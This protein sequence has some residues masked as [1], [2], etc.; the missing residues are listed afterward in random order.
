[1]SSHLLHLLEEESIKNVTTIEIKKY[2]FYTKIFMASGLISTSL[3]HLESAFL[4]GVRKVVWSH[5]FA[6]SCPVFPTP[7]IE[8]TVFSSL[9]VLG[10]FAV[11]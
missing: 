3:T 5:S 9:Y 10:S 8:E 7:F 6:C 4:Y 1:M 11:N 2:I